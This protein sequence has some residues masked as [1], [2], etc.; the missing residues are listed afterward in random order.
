MLVVEAGSYDSALAV[1]RAE[2]PDLAILDINIPGGSGFELCQALRRES[3]LPIL[4][5]TVRNEER[6][7]FAPGAQ[8]RRLPPSPTVPAP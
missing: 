8:C 3:K 4:M 5:L 6:T 1:F 2:Q 7:W